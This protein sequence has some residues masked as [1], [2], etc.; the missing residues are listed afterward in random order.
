MKEASE[1]AKKPM[2]AFCMEKKS[3][4]TSNVGRQAALLAFREEDDHAPEFL[5]QDFG[6]VVEGLF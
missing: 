5:D 2:P 1:K 4:Q 6:F 3:P